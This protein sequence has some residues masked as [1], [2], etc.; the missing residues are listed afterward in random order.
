MSESLVGKR[1]R[2]LAP[3]AETN[4]GGVEYREVTGEVK[5]EWLHE[6]PPGE[7]PTAIRRGDYEI[8]DWLRVDC[9]ETFGTLDTDKRYVEVIA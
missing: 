1:V 4:D 9:G 8:I 7:M 6:Y 3:V 5:E 2:F